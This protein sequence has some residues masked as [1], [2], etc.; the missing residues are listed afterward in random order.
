MEADIKAVE[1][2]NNQ[3]SCYISEINSDIE[4]EILEKGNRIRTRR[5]QGF[6]L[7]WKG[8]HKI[9]DK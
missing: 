6:E 1:T 4:I 9:T 5:I 7:L 2:E 8:Y 3:D